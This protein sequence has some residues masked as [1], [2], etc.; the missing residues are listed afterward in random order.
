MYFWL[1]LT[2]EKLGVVVHVFDRNS[3]QIAEGK[4]WTLHS[5]NEDVAA[6]N[7]LDSVHSLIDDE[8]MAV[9]SLN[10]DVEETSNGLLYNYKV[11]EQV[12]PPPDCVRYGLV[13]LS[14]R[15]DGDAKTFEDDDAPSS[16]SKGTI[17]DLDLEVE[18]GGSGSEINNKL[19]D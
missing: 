12:S 5:S 19:N 2:V 16:A 18:S 10:C 7:I 14:S 6:D 15:E 4:F 1:I 13:F 8:D 11:I 17:L 3:K 9:S